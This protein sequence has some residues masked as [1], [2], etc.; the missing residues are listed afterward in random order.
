[1]NRV[2]ITYNPSIDLVSSGSNQTAILLYELFKALNYEVVLLNIKSTDYDWWDTFPK[3]D[4]IKLSSVYQMKDLDLLIDIDAIVDYNYR[5][6]VAKKTVA[7]LRTFLQFDE[8]D[9][10]VYPEVTTNYRNF[11]NV[12]E[13]WCWDLL[14]SENTIPSIQT[15]FSCPIK[16]VP[17]IWSAT[18]ADNYFKNNTNSINTN[19]SNSESK[20]TVHIS[21]KNTNNSSSS[22]LPLVAVREM[23]LKGVLDAEYKCHN[24]EHILDNKFLKENILNNIE[25]S[26]MPIE[27]VKSE[28][29]SKWCNNHILFSHSRFTPLRIG[30]LNA[31]WAGIPVIHNSPIIKDL[32]PVL[33]N[34]FYFGNEITGICKAFSSYISNYELFYQVHN[35]IK[36]NIIDQWGIHSNIDKWTVILDNMFVTDVKVLV[37]DKVNN[38]VELEQKEIILAFSDFWPG[39]NHDDNFFTNM[40]R[41]E[42]NFRNIKVKGVKYTDSVKANVVLC[43]PFSSGWEHITHIPK[44][45]ITAENWKVPNDDSI[46]LYLTPSRTEDETHMRLPTWMTFIDWYSESDDVSSVNTDNNPN[47]LP[48]KLAMSVHPKKFS[49]RDEFCGFVVSNPVCQFRNEAFFLLNSYKKVNSGG[50]LYNN[51][52]GR[53]NLKYPGGGCGDIPKLKFFENHKFTLCF[54]NSQAPGYITE[55]VLHSKMAGCLPIYWGDTDTDSDFVPNSFIN[56]SQYNKSEDVVE[57]VKT[58]EANPEICEKI[59]STPILNEEKKQKALYTLSKIAKKILKIAL[60]GLTKK[61][62]V[63][64]DTNTI[65]IKGIDKIYVIN[66]DKRQDRFDSLIEAEPYLKDV[67]ERIPAVDG[68]TLRLNNFIYNLFEHN[69]FGWK[70]SII[71]CYL[72]H[73]TA[74]SKIASGFSNMTLV[75]EDDVRFNKD[76]INVWNKSISCIPED[77]EL[78]YLGGVLPPNKAGLSICLEKINEY[79]SYI[80][81]NT[82]FTPY[83]SNTFHFCAYSYILT[84]KGAQKL[85]EYLTNPNKVLFNGCDH[86]I[87]CSEVGLKKYIITPLL[88]YCFQEEDPVYVNSQFNDI[89]RKDTFDSDIWN[90]T[91]CFTD[92]DLNQIRKNDK[93]ITMYH[94]GELNE[95][96]LYEIKWMKELFK[97][98]F[99]FKEIK[100]LTKV[101]ENNSW[102]LVQKPHIEKFNQYFSYLK[103]KNIN[104]KVLHISDEYLTDSVEF[105]SFSNCKCVIRNYNRPDISGSHIL[106]I[107]L[108]FHHKGAKNKLFSDRKFIWSFHGTNWF[109]RQE[110]LYNI[111]DITP[112]VC[113]LTDKWNDLNQSKEGYYL[114]TLENSKFCPIL[115]GNNYETF[116]LYEALE[117]GTIPI[118]VRSVGDDLFWQFISKLGLINITSWDTAKQIMEQFMN[119]P[120]DAENYRNIIYNNWL[121]WKEEIC[122]F[123]GNMK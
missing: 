37:S 114:D 116:R 31:L 49:T 26:K 51:I 77:A 89:N 39:F 56:M 4:N 5:K 118:Y 58:L 104:F 75:L 110:Q 6:K 7:F 12:S 102:F 90:N 34:M 24:M 83:P 65:P 82:F 62:T 61:E 80:K 21:E 53:L 22:I 27:F 25:V 86:L 85:L 72:S 29:F 71:G 84:K 105:Y 64:K 48:V 96:N 100:D 52:G 17:F 69:I 16:R 94:M 106:T 111:L 121:E 109:N 32:H 60:N 19:S 70:K 2:G 103:D 10:S 13:V 93:A 38:K 123:I 54:E 23:F 50:E 8:M 28:P 115:R 66:L 97:S 79:W 67:I 1:M 108:G 74:W 41:H 101:V 81:S 33:D 44:I 113:H 43:G 91:E 42:C 92:S 35:Q 122:I 40:I 112:N 57:I 15:L 3:Y 119:N 63:E 88:S 20:W 120:S 46:S 95:S 11:E 78:I 36:A 99:A 107:P 45:Y 47:L 68:K 30:L 14:N 73:I 98:N 9:R 55:K 117:V 87:G 76:W 59:A 18:V